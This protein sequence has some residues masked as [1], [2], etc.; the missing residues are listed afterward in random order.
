MR[1]ARDHRIG[2]VFATMNRAEVALACLHSI[3]AQTYPPFITVVADNL[4]KD[5]TAARLREYATHSSELRVLEMPANLGNAGGI[6]AAMEYAFSRGAEGVWILDDDSHPRREALEKLLAMEWD[7]RK[8]RHSLQ[9]QPGTDRLSW[10][11][12]VVE[13]SGESR[14]TRHVSDL[15][16]EHQF[17]PPPPRGPGHLYPRRYESL[18]VP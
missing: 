7:K 4:S 13:P 11:M 8:V 9:I 12:V 16:E 17:S 15:P 6:Y 10:P 14:L 2:V 18:L 3:F 5:G 1:D